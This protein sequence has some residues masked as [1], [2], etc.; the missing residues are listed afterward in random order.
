MH[1]NNRQYDKTFV[2]VITRQ[3]SCTLCRERVIKKPIAYSTSIKPADKPAADI[4]KQ[5]KRLRQQASDRRYF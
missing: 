3:R 1:E 5:R 4:S 2:R